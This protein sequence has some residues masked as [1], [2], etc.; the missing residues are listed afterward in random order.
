MIILHVFHFIFFI[1]KK[2]KKKPWRHLAKRPNHFPCMVATQ[3]CLIVK[4]EINFAC[5]HRL[6]TWNVEI[7]IYVISCRPVKQWFWSVCISVFGGAHLFFLWMPCF[8][9]EAVGLV[10]NKAVKQ[11][12]KYRTDISWYV[13]FW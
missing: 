12:Y 7:G 2:K 13:L 6:G 5:C 9:L 10:P 8:R 4:H 11:R 1:K 3:P